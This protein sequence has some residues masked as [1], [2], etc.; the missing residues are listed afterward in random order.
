MRSVLF[1]CWLVCT[2]QKIT[3]DICPGCRQATLER[4]GCF[5]DVCDDVDQ[6]LSCGFLVRMGRML[7]LAPFLWGQ[8]ESDSTPPKRSRHQPPSSPETSGPLTTPPIRLARRQM[9]QYCQQLGMTLMDSWELEPIEQDGF[10]RFVLAGRAY[11]HPGFPEGMHTVT[12]VLARCATVH[13]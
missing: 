5:D 9:L 10:S 12:S 13:M 7:Q 8:L 1:G 4:D 6:L 2:P 11:G 3:H